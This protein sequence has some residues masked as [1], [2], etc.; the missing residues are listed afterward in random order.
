MS[1]RLAA[2]RNESPSLGII[3]S[4]SV[5]NSYAARHVKGYDAGKKISGVKVH[6]AVDILGLPISIYATTADI[7]DR[8]GALSMGAA[9]KESFATVQKCLVDGGY[10]GARFATAFQKVC[11]PAV[12]VVKR[13]ERH[14][15]IVL[16]KRWV[17]ERSFSWMDKC[18]RLWRNSERSLYNVRQMAVL[19]FT[20]LLLCRL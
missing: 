10:S 18:R 13:N 12:E 19:A 14:K 2:G 8:N 3:D 7:T 16:P 20:A 11:G 15:F 6:M 5:R 17:V 9:S 1:L 4:K